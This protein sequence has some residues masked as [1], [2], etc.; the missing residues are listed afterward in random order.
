MEHC[1]GWIRTRQRGEPELIIARRTTHHAHS[2]PPDPDF[3]TLTFPGEAATAATNAHTAHAHRT[4]VCLAPEAVAPPG[5]RALSFACFGA[6]SVESG[7]LGKSGR[8]TRRCWRQ[9]SFLTPVRFETGRPSANA[10]STDSL[11]VPWLCTF[12]SSSAPASLRQVTK[13]SSMRSVVHVIKRATIDSTGLDRPHCLA[14]TNFPS[15]RAIRVRPRQ[16]LRDHC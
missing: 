8:T 6:R 11:H 9:A 16:R 15:K 4:G 1:D 12:H 7:S 13:I 10:A 5:Q 3:S 14:N 2:P